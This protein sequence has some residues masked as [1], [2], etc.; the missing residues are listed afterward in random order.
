ML[1]CRLVVLET[2]GTVLSDFNFL[3]SSLMV[4]RH[5]LALGVEHILDYPLTKSLI[6]LA[7]VFSQTS[8][9]AL[10]SVRMYRCCPM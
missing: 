8:S 2:T 1:H 4:P 10:F 7:L 3:G 5:G 6:S 9:T